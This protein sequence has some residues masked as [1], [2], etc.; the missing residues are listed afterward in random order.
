M[1]VAILDTIEAVSQADSDSDDQG[2]SKL[3]EGSFVS[4]LGYGLDELPRR[5]EGDRCSTSGEI[6]NETTR[7]LSW[8][9]VVGVVRV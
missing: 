4:I 7:F 6:E 8:P 2:D 3:G 5:S 9:G 1:V